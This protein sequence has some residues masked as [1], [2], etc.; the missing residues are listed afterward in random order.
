MWVKN[1][2]ESQDS[3]TTIN[4]FFIW[5]AVKSVNQV[6]ISDVLRNEDSNNNNDLLI[7]FG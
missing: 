3:L 7:Y 2:I 1:V 6:I 4:N 5:F